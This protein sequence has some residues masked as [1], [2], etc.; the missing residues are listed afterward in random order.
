MN[1]SVYY[2]NIL[3]KLLILINIITKTISIKPF[4]LLDPSLSVMSHSTPI[5]YSIAG[6]DSGG[7]AGIQADIL[8]IHDLGGHGCTAITAL[9]AQNSV[10]GKD[11]G[12]CW[13]RRKKQ[14]E[15]RTIEREHGQ[16]TYTN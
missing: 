12:V 8:T 7:G 1:H 4:K 6:S 3:I 11:V 15:G 13:G 10:G 5:I 2:I 9:T 16:Y 14:N